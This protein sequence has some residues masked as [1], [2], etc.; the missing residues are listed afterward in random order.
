MADTE[1]DI[2]S[3]SI[4]SLRKRGMT[5]CKKP[6]MIHEEK[7]HQWRLPEYLKDVFLEIEIKLILLN[8]LQLLTSAH[9]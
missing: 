6:I 7:L 9:M 4:L 8:N 3:I 5:C 1:V 2:W